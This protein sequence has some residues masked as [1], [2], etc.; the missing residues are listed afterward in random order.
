MIKKFNAIRFNAKRINRLLMRAMVK[1]YVDVHDLSVN[2]RG[3]VLYR[4]MTRLDNND[5]FYGVQTE[6]DVYTTIK[7]IIKALV[8]DKH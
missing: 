4:I 5:Y 1:K 8:E 3:I 6:S 2:E 7:K